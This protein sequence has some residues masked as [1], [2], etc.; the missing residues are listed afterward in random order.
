M[1]EQTEL[2]QL[3]P[4]V[5]MVINAKNQGQG[6]LQD[7]WSHYGGRTDIDVAG[8]IFRVKWRVNFALARSQCT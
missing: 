3:N 5:I 4:Q 1:M 7:T 8:A 2:V 6:H